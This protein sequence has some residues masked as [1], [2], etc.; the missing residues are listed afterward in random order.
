MFDVTDVIYNIPE[1]TFE[2]FLEPE[3]IIALSAVSTATRYTA[4]AT[5]MRE[6]ILVIS[7]DYYVPLRTIAR[8]H[9]WHQYLDELYQVAIYVYK[10]K[11]SINYIDFLYHAIEYNDSMIYDVL[12]ASKDICSKIFNFVDTYN[13]DEITNMDSLMD[14][15]YEELYNQVVE[16]SYYGIRFVDEPPID[17]LLQDKLEQIR[18]YREKGVPML[19]E[20]T[21][22]YG[23]SI[24]QLCND[25]L[26]NI[27]RIYTTLAKLASERFNHRF[28]E[29]LFTD[30]EVSS[31]YN[32]LDIYPLDPN[33]RKLT[34]N[35]LAHE[36]A[37]M[38]RSNKYEQPN[39]PEAYGLSMSFALKQT[40][41]TAMALRDLELFLEY[42]RKFCNEC[43]ET[44]IRR[45]FQCNNLDIEQLVKLYN[46]FQGYKNV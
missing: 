46:L 31:E 6:M 23:N 25:L 44:Y 29:T 19:K 36:I 24:V 43:P 15:S 27:E 13:I 33:I 4:K 42:V 16:E 32:I 17:D 18:I 14:M 26:Y 21:T 39:N 11:K 7:E 41:I 38:P 8:E 9:E 3:D 12:I 40:V 20:L 2:E 5:R 35:Y 30:P 22:L 10:R 45:M 34:T 37:T 28:L 1:N